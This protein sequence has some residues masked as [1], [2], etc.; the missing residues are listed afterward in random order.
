M[1]N[2]IYNHMRIGEIRL[3]KNGFVLLEVILSVVILGVAVAAI[4]RSFTV[5]LATARKAQIVTTS[6]LL[7]QQV[8][9]EYEVVPPQEN[10]VEGAF[11]AIEEDAYNSD[12][13]VNELPSKYK[14]YYWVV[15]VEE[16]E[17]DYPDVSFEGER[18]EF[19]NLTKLSVTIV[20]DDGRLKRFTPVRMET[21]LT[22]TE[23]FTYTSKKDN[24]LY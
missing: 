6:C 1:R 23:K 20:Y 16:E 21:Y 3:G 8:L 10:H 13:T 2:G 22:N 4:L 7:A 19:E 5:S 17:L 15:D 12:G 14:N 11:G 18:E 24:M 9:E